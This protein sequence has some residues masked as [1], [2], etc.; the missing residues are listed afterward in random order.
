MP[1]HMMQA[2]LT[3]LGQFT[4]SR[5]FVLTD[6]LELPFGIDV[7]P[8]VNLTRHVP[9]TELMCTLH[10]YAHICWK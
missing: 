8:N 2:M 1:E 7:P 9:Q 10:I 4:E 6:A 3:A 5:A